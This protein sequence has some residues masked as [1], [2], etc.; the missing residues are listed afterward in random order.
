VQPAAHAALAAR[1]HDDQVAAQCLH[2]IENGLGRPVG[3]L[4][5]QAAWNPLGRSVGRGLGED[6]AGIAHALL[7]KH[8]SVEMAPQCPFVRRTEIGDGVKEADAGVQCFGQLHRLGGVG[9]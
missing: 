4:G 9:G 7:G 8:R 3:H 6:G 5:M 2:R 1:G